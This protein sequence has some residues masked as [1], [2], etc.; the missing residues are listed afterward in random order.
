MNILIGSDIH[1]SIYYAKKFF[2]KVHFYKPY[3]IILLGDLYYNGP[4][5]DLP[6]DY[7]PKEVV[8]LLNQYASSILAVNGN[9]DAEVDSWVSDFSIVDHMLL[10]Y[11]DKDIYL[12]HGHKENFSALPNNPGDIF[13]QGHTHIGV[14][15]RK[16][17]LI[18]ANPGSLSL[19]K[20]DHH[21]YIIMDEKGMKLLDLMDD[22]IYKELKF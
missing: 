5:N 12:T 22:H 11:F 10:H 20:D 6:K 14:L 1:G 13:L 3:K 16:E 7:S 15:E 19:P 4:R 17:N 2:D 9:C 21:S 8:L 18:L